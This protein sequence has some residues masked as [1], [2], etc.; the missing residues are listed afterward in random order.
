MFRYLGIR[1]NNSPFFESGDAD[2]YGLPTGIGP[3]PFSN[4]K[5]SVL[6]PLWLFDNKK[7]FRL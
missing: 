5:D 7:I 6:I 2:G 3:V 1:F 4:K